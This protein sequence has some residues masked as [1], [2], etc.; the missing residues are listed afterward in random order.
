MWAHNLDQCACRTSNMKI[1]NRIRVSQCSQ[2]DI[3]E[4]LPLLCAHRGW[5]WKEKWQRLLHRLHYY[6][7]MCTG[8]F[9]RCLWCFGETISN[10]EPRGEL[11]CRELNAHLPAGQKGTGHLLPSDSRGHL[12]QRL[13]SHWQNHRARK[14]KKGAS[15]CKCTWVKGGFSVC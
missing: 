13:L 2:R 4:V 1:C 8:W 6:L 3:W 11:S 12:W 15:G 14:G 7:F 10:T 5:K 9:Y